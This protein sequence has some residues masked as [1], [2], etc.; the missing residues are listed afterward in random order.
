[1]FSLAA[2]GKT[3]RKGMPNPLRLAV[4]AN[5]HFDTVRLPFPPAFLQRIGLA[6]GAPVGRARRLRGDVRPGDGELARDGRRMRRLTLRERF[7]VVMAIMGLLVLAAVGSV[8]R[9][10]GL[11]DPRRASVA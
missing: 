8:G 5:A 9:W 11:L 3:N 6:L 10:V 2:D 4:I 7:Y 1:M